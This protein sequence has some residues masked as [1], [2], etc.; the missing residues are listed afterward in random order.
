MDE[1]EAESVRFEET[2]FIQDQVSL[3]TPTGI[4]MTLAMVVAAAVLCGVAIFLS[5]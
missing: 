1:P 3:Q 4:L 2:P 5:F